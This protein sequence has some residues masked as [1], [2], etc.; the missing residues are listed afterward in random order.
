MII[1]NGEILAIDH[2][3]HDNTLSGNGTSAKPVGLSKS[4]KDLID[5]KVNKDDFDTYK[6]SVANQIRDINNTITADESSLESYKETVAANFTAVDKQITD[7]ANDFNDFKNTTQNKFTE[8]DGTF[9]N[10]ERQIE[11]LETGKQPVGDYV[12]TNEFNSYK[13]TV[14]GKF[15]TVNE[16][17]DATNTN[18]ENNYYDIIITHQDES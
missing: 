3:A 5:S 13:E 17:I 8:V 16:R 6:S 9:T 14:D 2:I 4:T 10:V 11:A 18:L 15:T 1:K 12:V 7:V